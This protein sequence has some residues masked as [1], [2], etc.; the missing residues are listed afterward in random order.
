MTSQEQPFLVRMTIHNVDDNQV[1]FSNENE[2]Q[3]IEVIPGQGHIFPKIEELLPSMTIG[4][5]KSL[6]LEKEDAFGD[7]VKEAVQEVPLERLTEELRV[8]GTKISAQTQNDQPVQGTVVSIEDEVAIIDFNH[9]LAGKKIEVE[10]A[11]V[12][13][14][15][16]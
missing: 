3:P 12:E 14:A 13:D 8:P 5:K 9:P 4:E 6:T 1:F 16:K 11:I 7:K 15:A 2:A 10:F